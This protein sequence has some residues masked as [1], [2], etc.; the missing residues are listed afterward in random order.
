MCLHLIPLL[1]EESNAAQSTKQH[2]NTLPEVSEPEKYHVLFTSHHLISPT[3][4][5]NLQKWAAELSLRGFAKVG[6]PGAIYAEGSREDI[7]DFVG[8]VKAMQ[9]LALKVRFEE[10]LD[11]EKYGQLNLGYD[12]EISGPGA[13]GKD[14]GTNWIELEKV[15]EVVEVMRRSGRE[16]LVTEMG[17]GTSSANAS[18]ART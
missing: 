4:R 13:G 14:R 15:G 12:D 16:E 5:R 3:K 7:A 8:R 17:L 18:T 11:L 10:R 6:Y 9:W 1:H 2:S